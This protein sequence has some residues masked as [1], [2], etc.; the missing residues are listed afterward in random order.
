MRVYKK[1]R[2]V[3]Y[4]KGDLISKQLPLMLNIHLANRFIEQ[5]IW[6]SLSN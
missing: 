3:M 2:K 1:K 6:R 5:T 4:K